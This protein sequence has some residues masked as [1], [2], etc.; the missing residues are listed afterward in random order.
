MSNRSKRVL[1]LSSDFFSF[2]KCMY[3]LFFIVIVLKAMIMF[4]VNTYLKYHR[5]GKHNVD[6]I[7]QRLVLSHGR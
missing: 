5:F 1:K 7:L 3:T 4:K 2:I 6:V